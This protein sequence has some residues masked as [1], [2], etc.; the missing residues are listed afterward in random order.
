MLGF[1]QSFQDGTSRVTRAWINLTLTDGSSLEYHE[2]RVMMNGIIRDSSTSV[3]GQFTV[4]AAV[5]GKMTVILDNSD[6]ELSAYDFRGATMVVWLGGECP[7]LKAG[8]HPDAD[9]TEGTQFTITG[10]TPEQLELFTVNTQL[11][12]GITDGEHDFGRT[13]ITAVSTSGDVTSITVHDEITI[14]T[15]TF[16]SISQAE[17]VNAGRYYIDE[18]TYD[19]AT[20]TLVGYDDMVKFDIPCKDTTI[21]S[22]WH[23]ALTPGWLIN[24]ISWYPEVGVHLYNSAS[25]LPNPLGVAITYA[26]AQLDTMTLHDVVSACCQLMGY[27]AHIIY[28]PSSGEYRLKLDWY[29]TSQLT[30]NQYDGGTFNTN[31]TPYSD[32]A[33]LDGGSFNPWDTGDVANGGTFG[34][35]TGVHIIPSPYDLSVDTDD[36]L[37]TGVS[38]ILEPTDNIN[39]DDSTETYTKTLGTEGYIIQITGNP[40]IDTT[41]KADSVCT[42]LYNKINGMRFR[43]LSA[44]VVENPAME[45]GDVAIITGRNE[46]T[47]GCF[48]SRVTYTVNAATQISCDA[49]STMQNLKA[50]FSGAQK[51][52]AMV[53]R[54]ATERAVSNAETAM[55]GVLTSYAS[56]RGLYQY[57][58]TD[59]SGGT[60]Y[61]YGNAPTLASSNIRWR[62]SAGSIMVSSDYGQTWNSALSADGSAVMQSLYAVGIN[63]DYIEAGNL[64]LGGTTKNVDGNFY[65]KDAQGNL[66]VTMNKNGI[67]NGKTSIND[68]TNTG[69]YLS[70]DGFIIGDGD[71]ERYVRITPDG[72]VYIHDNTNFTSAGDI[73]DDDVTPPIDQLV[74]FVIEGEDENGTIRRSY[75]SSN[76][77]V[78]GEY[79][80]AGGYADTFHVYSDGDIESDGQAVING[81]ISSENRYV[82][83]TST[84]AGSIIK[85]MGVYERGST[86]AQVYLGIRLADG[87]TYYVDLN[88][89]DSR[90]KKDISDS[91]INALDVINKIQHRSFTWKKNGFKAENGYIAQELRNVIPT[92]VHPVKQGDGTELLQVSTSEIVP[93]LSKAIQ[94]LSAKV[95]ALEARLAELEGN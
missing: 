94:E 89:S 25:S 36:V 15:S 30:A 18:Y 70:N 34:D 63:A 86:V 3:D 75:L 85:Y 60:I 26:P 72:F 57:T 19:G 29:N 17:K 69:F 41:A 9:V 5:T 44:S 52:Q 58:E 27:Y 66:R 65:L 74:S 11:D 81:T 32:G 2:D 33:T 93:Y 64:T 46:N 83:T 82:I 79:N 21:G 68:T 56:S 95:D 38:V 48:L 1:S 50:R 37:I 24:A 20:V 53:Q 92:A 10:L 87:S 67:F 78:V 16:V 90:L 62:I 73:G 23:S 55:I 28:V 12:F 47:Y 88:T 71:A 31:T 22:V 6:E 77:L 49:E 61:I 59:L 40:F 84:G 7:V 8:L 42:F 51:I 13:Y 35:R 43:P 54:V 4:G 76:E 80:T 39:A 14:T 45:A 91:T